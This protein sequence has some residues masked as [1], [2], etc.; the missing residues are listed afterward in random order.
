MKGLRGNGPQR[1]AAWL[2]GAKARISCFMP[3]RRFFSLTFIGVALTLF[4][5]LK[6]PTTKTSAI[7]TKKQPADFK[8]IILGSRQGVEVSV[9]RATASQSCQ[10]LWADLRNLDLRRLNEDV[11][12]GCLLL[13]E[14]AAC[15]AR[16][17]AL[18][19]AH[20]AYA[21]ACA[22]FT[23]AAI[24]KKGVSDLDDQ[25]QACFLT[26][27]AYRAAVGDWLTQGVAL[28]A[29]DD[30]QILGDKLMNELFSSQRGE[31]TAIPRLREVAARLNQINPGIYATTKI[32]AIGQLTE[33][34]AVGTSEAWETARKATEKLESFSTNDPELK[35]LGLWV[36]TEGLNPAKLYDEAQAMVK[37]NPQSGLGYFYMAFAEAGLGNRHQVEALFL[38]AVEAEPNN[39]TFARA[40]EN[41]RARRPIPPPFS[42][43]FNLKVTELMERP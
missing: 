20:K 4:W 10:D 17:E 27:V 30:A 18:D 41:F 36:R 39:P 16:P 37:A 32:V 12:R 23:D 3:L 24:D 11:F 1:F 29:I 42:F 26:L 8:Q 40:L 35:T 31:A 7:P 25:A 34:L 14:A 13:P 6:T 19:L 22:L 43:D 33:A 21:K 2:K 9:P 5:V 15:S 38:S 28:E